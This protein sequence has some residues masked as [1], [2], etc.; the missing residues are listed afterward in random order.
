MSNSLLYI[1]ASPGLYSSSGFGITTNINRRIQAYMSHIGP[2]ADNFE[3]KYV[4]K[5]LSG[6]I[7]TLE[8]DIKGLLSHDV[9][10]PEHQS[11]GNIW[12]TEWT[13]TTP[14]NNLKELVDKTI[15]DNFYD[16]SLYKTNL[17]LQ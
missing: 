16:I 9:W 11:T 4:Y 10:Q 5:G 8:D 2:L 1:F 15:S 3:M 14:Y 6:L 7:E 13:I 12:Y 17:K